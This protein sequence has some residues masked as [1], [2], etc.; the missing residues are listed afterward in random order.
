MQAQEAAAAPLSEQVVLEAIAAAVGLDNAQRTAAE[1]ALQAWEKDAAPGF[2]ASLVQIVQQTDAA[3]QA[4]LMAAIVAKNAVGSSWRKTMGTK[5]WS[6]VPSEEKAFVRS[7]V[8]GML[9]SDPSEQV[10]LQLTL[11]IANMA[12]FDYPQD[13]PHLLSALVDAVDWD[14]PGTSPAAKVRAM[15]TVKHVVARLS[16]KRPSIN[17]LE[18][19]A[20]GPGLQALVAGRVG[21]LKAYAP[22][23][24]ACGRLRPAD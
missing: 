21:E 15:R 20:A 4:R 19:A 17:T 18:Q 6:R 22:L 2:I 1:A 14:M 23:V 5:E 10:A 24:P 3:P 8:E 16:T 9:L 11:L 7:A 12:Q 13:W